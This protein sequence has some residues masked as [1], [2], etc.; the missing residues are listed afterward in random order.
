MFNFVKQENGN[1]EYNDII[2]II[3]DK[4]T[5]PEKL[6]NLYKTK[7]PIKHRA[8]CIIKTNLDVKKAVLFEN[9][10]GM[11]S[12]FNSKYIEYVDNFL[13]AKCFLLNSGDEDNENG[14]ILCL[15]FGNRLI[16]VAPLI[17]SDCSVITY[18]R[19]EAPNKEIK[20]FMKLYSKVK[21]YGD[22][23]RVSTREICENLQGVANAECRIFNDE[24][25]E[26]D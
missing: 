22:K 3:K 19:D 24:D 23:Y 12:F 9:E 20:D 5:F 14:G 8:S 16:I 4:E 25:D 17:Y 26:L 21:D 13:G 2:I 1:Y 6:T 11:K 18:L 10:N 7:S 15:K